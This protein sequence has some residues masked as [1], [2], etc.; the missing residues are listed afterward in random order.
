MITGRVA[1][2]VLAAVRLIAVG[3]GGDDEGDES[4]DTTTA[5]AVSGGEEGAGF[6]LSH[7]SGT[8]R[9][10][11]SL[12]F[13]RSHSAVF[14]NRQPAGRPSP[15][16]CDYSPIASPEA[17]GLHASHLFETSPACQ[18]VSPIWGRVEA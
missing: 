11:A 18:I 16:G 12:F 13:A 7:R 6:P 8:F 2:V 4:G 1:L 14:A 17:P 9:E 15:P 10:A 3:C 5:L